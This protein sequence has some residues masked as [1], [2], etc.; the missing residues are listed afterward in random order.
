VQ[1]DIWSLGITACEMARGYP[2][3]ASLTAMQVLMKTMRDK[4]P[5]LRDYPVR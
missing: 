1:A 5:S 2:P 4:P 3:Y